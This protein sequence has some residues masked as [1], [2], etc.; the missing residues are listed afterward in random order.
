MLDAKKIAAVTPCSSIRPVSP[1]VFYPLHEGAGTIAK[2]LLGN[3][4]D[5][6]LN[7]TGTPW[8][9]RPMVTFNGTD[10]WLNAGNEYLRSLW[11]L[12]TIN[13]QTLFIAFDYWH[14]GDLTSNEAVI[15]VGNIHA[16]NGG[17]EVRINASQQFALIVRGEGGTADENNTFSP[18]A[19]SSR[20]N[21]R[22]PVAL[23]IRGTSDTTV[24]VNI[25][26]D[27]TPFVS[28]SGINLVPFSATSPLYQLGDG[29]TIGAAGGSIGT[30]NRL[31]N[32]GNSNCRIGNVMLGRFGW[33]GGSVFSKAAQQLNDLPGEFPLALGG[34]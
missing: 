26:V 15:C 34:V 19:I 2:C 16:S 25:Y 18:V 4:P 22:M 32:S 31:S 9:N 6:T 27:G 14:D 24:D 11:E 28:T 29:L 5:L 1:C 17:L 20:G 21:R 7:G 13:G 8:I 12:R 23:E 30:K 3:G 10:N 33:Q